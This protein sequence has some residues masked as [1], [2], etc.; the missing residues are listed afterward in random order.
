MAVNLARVEMLKTARGAHR[1][2]VF[3]KI[4]QSLRFNPLSAGASIQV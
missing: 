2:P 4:R 1:L 3:D